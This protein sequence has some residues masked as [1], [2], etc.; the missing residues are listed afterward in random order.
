MR[1]GAHP[2]DTAMRGE[3]KR[4]R[5]SYVQRVPAP[6]A[7]GYEY[8]FVDRLGKIAGRVLEALV[9]LDGDA[10]LEEIAEAV[11]AKRPR[12]LRRRQIA[13]LERAGIV[14]IEGARVI[15]TDDWAEKVGLA[16][17]LGGEYD[18]ERRM[19]DRH[20]RARQA[21]KERHT[22]KPDRG[23]TEADMQQRRERRRRR[24]EIAQAVREGMRE[25]F[26]AEAVIGADGFL[27]DLQP[28]PRQSR[29]E[30][31]DNGVR[32]H[33]PLCECEWC[34][35][36]ITPRYARPSRVGAA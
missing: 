5:W 8:F 27:E 29:P 18:A 25:D 33:G 17:E 31:D 10:P 2:G 22:T 15:L 36:P 9:D 7:G 32:V 24:R 6:D 20:A 3:I 19:R 13:R 14:R 12:D 30:P 1:G 21:F 23:P 16:R 26:A 35:E 28:A 34:D 4:L 11:D